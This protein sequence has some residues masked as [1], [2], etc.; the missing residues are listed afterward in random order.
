M[1]R[2]RTRGPRDFP[3][4]ASTTG[5]GTSA[6]RVVA[7]RT[8]VGSATVTVTVTA[9]VTVIAIAIATETETETE[10][11]T[12]IEIGIGT[13]AIDEREARPAGVSG[14]TAA[15]AGDGAAALRL[16]GRIDLMSGY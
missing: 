7:V 9:I 12:G 1:P 3:F 13:A 11:G 2:K 15:E 10:I 5:G 14:A 8:E 6:G 4:R 16:K